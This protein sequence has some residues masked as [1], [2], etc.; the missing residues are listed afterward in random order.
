MKIVTTELPGV[1]I[2]EPQVFHDP[3]GVFLETYHRLRYREAGLDVEFVQDNLSRSCRGT[4][5]GLHYQIEHAQ[6]KLCQVTC[7][8]AFDVALDLRRE[9]P[10]FGRWT[11][12]ILSEAN[13][14]QAYIPPGFAHG[15]CALSETV[16][17][18]YKCTDFYFPEH[19]RTVLWND[20][21]LNIP[22]PIGDP[23]LSENDCR[24]ALFANAPYFEG[25]SWA[26]SGPSLG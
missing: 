13:R 4:L 10:T 19:E 8:E 9:S 2:F 5:R 3:R 25:K 1:V 11:R 14:R 23:L 17:F 16:D 6:G 24:G 20:P 26:P 21:Q 22:W 18:L 12:I 15:Y 7:G